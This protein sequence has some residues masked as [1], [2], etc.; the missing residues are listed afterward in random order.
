MNTA[1]KDFLHLISRSPDRGE[2]WRSIS[3]AL[4]PLCKAMA[5]ALP[6]LLEFE[7]GSNRIRLTEMGEGALLAV[8]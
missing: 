3:H 6:S 7:E 2:G 1:Q 5:E 8:S 4:L